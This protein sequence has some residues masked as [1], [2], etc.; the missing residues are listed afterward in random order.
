MT[1]TMSLKDLKKSRAIWRR[2]ELWRAARLKRAKS[3]ADKLKWQ[4]LLAEAHRKRARR[5]RQIADA[6]QPHEMSTKGL[7]FLTR[8]EG[9]I[10]YAYNDAATDRFRQQPKGH[11]TFGVGHLI[12]HGPLTK[13]DQAKWG[14]PTS[15]KSMAFVL[16]V[17][18]DDL[19]DREKAIASLVH[20]RVTAHEFDAL[21]SLAF[22]IGLGGFAGS[23]VLRKLNAGDRQGA[24]DAFRMWA[25]PAV[26]AGRRERERALFLHGTYA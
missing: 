16:D 22:N 11:A 8:Q 26:L 13:A 24:A 2:R 25:R 15:P 10:R 18:D 3:R 21:M 5:D 20:V 7:E 6:T 4:G 14:T 17:L 23:T 12:H 1:T 9:V 19:K